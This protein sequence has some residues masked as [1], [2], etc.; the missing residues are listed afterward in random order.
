MAG[1][2]RAQWLLRR[3]DG[4]LGG[5]IRFEYAGERCTVEVQ[6]GQV[7]RTARAVLLD[8][9][10]ATF[11][12]GAAD[13]A[14]PRSFRAEEIAPY[15]R[16]AVVQGDA[17]LYVAGE[18]ADF[19]AMRRLLQKPARPAQASPRPAREKPRAEPPAPR[20]KAAASAKEGWQL[21]AHSAP[22]MPTRITGRFTRQG[23]IAATLHG[24]AGLYA[25]E[26]PPGLAGYQWENGYWVRVVGE[27]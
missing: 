24:I 13:Q 5:F 6:A 4:S 8:E 12:L 9:G 19:D 17:L 26:P 27:S 16:A 21:Q 10:G 14:S 23:R 2:R 1:F 3:Q 15:A 11:S 7:A 22:G 20:E 18:G 25:P